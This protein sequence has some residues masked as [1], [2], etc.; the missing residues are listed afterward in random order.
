MFYILMKYSV[1]IIIFSTSITNKHIVS[2]R[3]MKK[4]V[5]HLALEN[6]Y[7]IG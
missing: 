5:L 3:V 7:L 1:G 4:T 2:G 6:L